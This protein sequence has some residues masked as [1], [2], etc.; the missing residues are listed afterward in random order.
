MGYF[1]KA[2]KDLV[3]GIR[4][5]SSQELPG[6]ETFSLGKLK[7]PRK[8]LRMSEFIKKQ[9]EKVV[10]CKNEFSSKTSEQFGIRMKSTLS[11][12]GDSCK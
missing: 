3:T 12:A 7:V 2:F 8:G 5:A 10:F 6:F 4:I 11:V 1:L 9:L